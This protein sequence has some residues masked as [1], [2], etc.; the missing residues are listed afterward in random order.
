[1]APASGGLGPS[2]VDGGSAMQQICNVRGP[3][4]GC[5]ARIAFDTLRPVI[6]PSYPYGQF[7]LDSGQVLNG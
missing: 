7:L 2:M 1:M 3:E 4:K 5:S 6:T